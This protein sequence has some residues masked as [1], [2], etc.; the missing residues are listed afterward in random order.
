MMVQ[1]HECLGSGLAA[2]GPHVFLGLLP[3]NLEAEDLTEV[4]VWLFP[5][6]KQY[7]IGAQL[8][9]FVEILDMIRQMKNKSKKV[10]KSF[11]SKEIG[12]SFI[13]FYLI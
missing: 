6:V 12:C 8:S 3:F 13:C 4:N 10:R 11:L 5:I 1:L 9:F 2:M 7:T